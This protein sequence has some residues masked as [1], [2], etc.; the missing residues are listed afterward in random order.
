MRRFALLLALGACDIDRADTTAAPAPDDG[1]S[2]DESSTGASTSD[3]DDADADLCGNDRIDPG[4]AC[5]DGPLNATDGWCMP[6]GTVIYGGV[7]R[8]CKPA[9][10]GD[11]FT[12]GDEECDDQPESGSDH[13]ACTNAC[14]LA[15]CGDGYRQPG[16]QCDDG[17]AVEGD[18]C[19]GCAL[20]G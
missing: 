18:G 17:N 20:D 2:G 8:S 4:E 6:A 10:C 13:D 11:G 12:N 5:D 7:D 3:G 16:E 19:T 9:L 1:T 15:S 14:K